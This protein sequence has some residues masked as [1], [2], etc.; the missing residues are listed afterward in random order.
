M[1]N[2][3]KFFWLI[4]SNL[5]ND[6]RNYSKI[7][8]NKVSQGKV[9]PHTSLFDAQVL[10]TPLDSEETFLSPGRAPEVPRDPIVISIL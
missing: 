10:T 5:T 8:R 9:G 4:K 1:F 7:T 6:R 2:Y 3:S